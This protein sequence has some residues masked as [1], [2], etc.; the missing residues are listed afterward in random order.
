MRDDSDISY[1]AKVANLSN[2]VAIS[3]GTQE[4]MAGLL[5]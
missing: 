3:H 5:R 2:A 4:L 1:Y